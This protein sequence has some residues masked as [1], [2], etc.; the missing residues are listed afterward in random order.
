LRPRPAS[1][2]MDRLVHPLRVRAPLPLNRRYARGQRHLARPPL[3][4]TVP[5]HG[6]LSVRR[7]QMHVRQIIIWMLLVMNFKDHVWSSKNF[8]IICS[9]DHFSNH[10]PVGKFTETFDVLIFILINTTRTF[11][12]IFYPGQPTWV[13]T[14]LC[15]YYPVLYFFPFT[16]VHSILVYLSGPIVFSTTSLQDVLVYLYCNMY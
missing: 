14:Y 8:G 12:K 10:F 2:L 1:L 7:Q 16:L 6:E 11:L 9:F 3:S 15:G 13:S 5:R 4:T